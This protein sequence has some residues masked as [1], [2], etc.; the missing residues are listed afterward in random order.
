MYV[1]LFAIVCLNLAQPDSCVREKI[2][3]SQ[4]EQMSITDCMGL[5]GLVTAKKFVENHALYHDWKL[6]GWA[7]QIGNR[8]A[9]DKGKA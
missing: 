9:P 1:T 4:V 8:A 2:T 3:D 7:C 6:K 5:N